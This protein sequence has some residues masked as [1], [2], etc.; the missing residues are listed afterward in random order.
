MNNKLTQR[1]AIFINVKESEV[2]AINPHLV[3]L[4]SSSPGANSYLDIG[5][6]CYTR[7]SEIPPPP[8]TACPVDP[9]SLDH[10][11]IPFT[12]ALIAYI[13]GLKTRSTAHS[14]YVGVKAFIGWIDSNVINL[15]CSPAQGKPPEAASRHGRRAM[16]RPLPLNQAV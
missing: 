3:V 14:V 7:R 4:I 11:R 15:S 8:R 6:F 2:E 5:S 16:T 12:K 13:K 1:P 9:S 10:S